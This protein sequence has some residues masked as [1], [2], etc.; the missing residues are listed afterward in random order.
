LN[1]CKI[2]TRGNTR[3]GCQF[4]WFHFAAL[5]ALSSAGP[6]INATSIAAKARHTRLTPRISKRLGFIGTPNNER[7]LRAIWR[8]IYLP[9]PARA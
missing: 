4:D 5:R 7:A 3:E 8:A 9:D 2:E 6:I 1:D